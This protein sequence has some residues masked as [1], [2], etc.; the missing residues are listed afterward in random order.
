MQVVVAHERGR[1]R[2]VPL[3][4]ELHRGVEHVAPRLRREADD[5]QELRRAG[6]VP[7]VVQHAGQVL[8]LEA[9]LD[10]VQEPLAGRPGT[11]MQA[12]ATGGAAEVPAVLRVEAAPLD[13]MI[14][15]QHTSEPSSRIALLEWRAAFGG[16]LESWNSTDLLR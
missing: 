12:T 4:T 5:P 9:V 7:Q 14:E 3:L 11:R 13:S 2:P 16:A 6:R 15:V 8:Y 10:Q 1:A